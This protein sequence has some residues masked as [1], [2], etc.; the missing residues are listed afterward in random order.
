MRK[1]LRDV[2]TVTPRTTKVCKAALTALI[3]PLI[4]KPR[5]CAACSLSTLTLAACSTPDSTVPTTSTRVPTPSARPFG[6]LAAAPFTGW[7][8]TLKLE[9]EVNAVTR[10][11]ILAPAR[12]GSATVALPKALTLKRVA[13]GAA[14]CTRK[15]TNWP[16]ARSAGT[17]AAPA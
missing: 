8:L 1:S 12:S 9:G 10:P 7:P 13:V 2:P 3:E 16:T 11:L 14:L 15:R 4:S 6:K 17:P 5:P